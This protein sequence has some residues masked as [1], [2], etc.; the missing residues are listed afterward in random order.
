MYVM[1]PNDKI[2]IIGK[3]I[4]M[5]SSDLVICEPIRFDAVIYENYK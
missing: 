4:D 5:M 3:Q 1:I 2:Q